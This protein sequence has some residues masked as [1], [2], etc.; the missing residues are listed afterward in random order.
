LKYFLFGIG[1]SIIGILISIVF[2]G[3]DK[4]YL[5]TGSIGL[6]F[7][8]IS[9]VMSGSMVSGDKM[10]ANFATE[11]AEDRRE[12]NRTTLKSML[13]GLPSVLTSVLLYYLIT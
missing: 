10:R 5:V 2:W 1:L 7:L 6:I 4:A 3:I 13:L 8:G 9:M 11:S 12:R